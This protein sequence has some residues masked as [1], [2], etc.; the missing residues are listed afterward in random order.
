MTQGLK[1]LTSLVEDLQSVPNN[2]M[3]V[4]TSWN[5]S[6]RG[7]GAFMD[8]LTTIHNSAQTLKK[9]KPQNTLTQTHVQEQYLNCCTTVQN[10]LSA[11]EVVKIFSPN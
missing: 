4:T 7:P 9:K 2:H 10:F 3:I 8:S 6:A 11:L 1:A 5:S